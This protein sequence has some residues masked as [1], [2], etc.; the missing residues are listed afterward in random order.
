MLQPQEAIN[1]FLP[2]RITEVNNNVVFMSV[3]L[4]P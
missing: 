4:F 1:Y 3:K 2:I